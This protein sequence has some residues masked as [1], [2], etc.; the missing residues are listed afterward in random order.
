MVG[1]GDDFRQFDSDLSQRTFF[2]ITEIYGFYVLNFIDFLE[3]KL[4]TFRFFKGYFRVGWNRS[5]F[6]SGFHVFLLVHSDRLHAC[7]GKLD[8][9]RS[10]RDI[11]TEIPQRELVR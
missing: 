6:H 4:K 5:S 8:V 2:R 7:Y 1:G 9:I 10:Q 11:L 3:R